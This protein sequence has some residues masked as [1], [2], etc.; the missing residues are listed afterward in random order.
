MR[1]RRLCKS[2]YAAAIVIGPGRVLQYTKCA[3]QLQMQL[4]ICRYLCICMD[5]VSDRAVI[6]SPGPEMCIQVN[7]LSFRSIVGIYEIALRFVQVGATKTDKVLA[8]ILGLQLLF[9]I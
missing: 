2:A 9:F 4:H 7:R 8:R 6:M 5:A 3:N 1:R